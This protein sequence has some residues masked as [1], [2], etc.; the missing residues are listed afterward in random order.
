MPEAKAELFFDT[1]TREGPWSHELQQ[2]LLQSPAD[3]LCKV[4]PLPHQRATFS[5]CLL[6]YESHSQGLLPQGWCPAERSKPLNQHSTRM[7]LS[8][9]GLAWVMGSPL[10]N[11]G[12]TRKAVHSYSGLDHGAHCRAMDGVHFRSHGLQVWKRVVTWR[13]LRA[14]LR[15][16]AKG[17]WAAGQQRSLAGSE[18]CP[19]HVRIIVR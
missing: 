2:Q 12:G 11:H 14:F 18:M 9:P 6:K 1:C 15:R 10:N 16:G 19:L 17:S 13:K 7:F 8:L 4:S 5:V 3:R